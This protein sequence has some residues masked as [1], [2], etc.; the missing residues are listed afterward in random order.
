MRV[1]QLKNILTKVIRILDAYDD[2]S[3][4]QMLDDI[5]AMKGH[6]IPLKPET[7]TLKTEPANFDKI[8][9]QINRSADYQTV[10]DLLTELDKNTLLGFAKF[11][12]VRVDKKDSKVAIARIISGHLRFPELNRKISERSQFSS[13]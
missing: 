7:K 8:R 5:L 11:V 4:E 6:P 9:D 2:K 1:K 12:D 13:G 10:V 3:I